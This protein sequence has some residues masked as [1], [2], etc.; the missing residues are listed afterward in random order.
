[1]QKGPGEGAALGEHSC[2]CS[3]SQRPGQRGR[4][5]ES[6][7]GG[8][9]IASRALVGVKES[10]DVGGFGVVQGLLP[11][12]AGLPMHHVERSPGWDSPVDCQSCSFLVGCPAGHY[13]VS[14]FDK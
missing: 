4:T 10:G 1:M 7:V 3:K 14:S 13:P 6:W 2:R 11:W 5:G 12:R 9:T 8:L